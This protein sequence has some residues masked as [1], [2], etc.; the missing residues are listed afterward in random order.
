MGTDKKN[1]I[2]LDSIEEAIEAIKRGEII[3]VVDDED[4]E[5]EGDF[6]C[7]AECIT[8]EIINFM[9]TNGRG[10]ICCSLLEERCAA[11]DL[12]LMVGKNTASLETPFTISVDLLGHGCTTGISAS[13][14]AKTIKALVD[15]DTKPEELGRPGHIFPLMAKSGGVLRRSGHTEAAVD[16][17]RLAGLSPAGVLVEIMNEDGTMARL[18][19]LKKVA[20]KFDLKLVSIRDLIEYRLRNDS[21][22]KREISV[23][24]PTKYGVF[25]LVAFRQI[26][27]N[28]MHMAFKLGEWEKDEVVTVRVHTADLNDDVFGV[29]LFDNSISLHDSLEKLKEI[30]KG[31]LVYMKQ[32]NI[33]RN[34][35]A[36]LKGLKLKEQGLLTEEAI[37]EMGISMD[38]RDYGIG[39][40]ILRD[41]GV[42]KMRLL[43]NQKVK[44]AGLEGYDL[45]I[46]ETV[47]VK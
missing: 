29:S 18:N 7:A 5:N 30:G 10:L 42:S 28:D 20:K 25:D 47:P 4:R 36:Q 24:Y 41:M 11:L 34:F 1:A 40:Q 38:D 27:T 6:I 39:A 23:Q 26:N 15:P 2:M 35:I 32:D 14:R 19:D 33:S 44:R 17:A 9:A 22:I 13:D 31:V 3:I 12:E 8:P 16:F 45:E 43:T 46:I 21:L 37:N